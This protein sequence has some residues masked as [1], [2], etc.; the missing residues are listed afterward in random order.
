MLIEKPYKYI[1][2][3]FFTF[4]EKEQGPQGPQKLSSLKSLKIQNSLTPMQGIFTPVTIING[5]LIN[6][7]KNVQIYGD[8]VLKVK[9]PVSEGA[10]LLTMRINPIICVS[11]KFY[12][13]CTAF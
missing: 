8:M 2:N 6:P 11:V 5:F 7:V 9:R 4:L 1:D 13:F 12:T 10:G 3:N